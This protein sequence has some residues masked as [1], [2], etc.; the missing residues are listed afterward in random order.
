MTLQIPASLREDHAHIHGALVA[1][2]LLVGELV[3]L[4]G[5]AQ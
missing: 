3:G 2:A 5:S 1:A 4:R